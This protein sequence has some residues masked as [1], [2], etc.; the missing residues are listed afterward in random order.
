MYPTSFNAEEE[1]PRSASSE[2]F[3]LLTATPERQKSIDPL[4]F[5]LLAFAVCALGYLAYVYLDRAT[6]QAAEE[7]KFQALMA[8]AQGGEQGGGARSYADGSIGRLTIEAA[9]VSVLVGP[10][11]D[12]LSLRRGAGHIGGTKWPGQRGN[13]GIAGHRDEAFRGLRKLRVG[14]RIRLE[15]PRGSFSYAV[16]SLRTVS[17][18]RVDVLGDSDYQTVTLVTCYPFDYIGSAPLRFVVRARDRKS[19]V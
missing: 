5:G 2:G 12:D 1:A 19:V 8:S 7:K 18:Q 16:E 4:S 15:T 6:Y 13:V 3:P 17:P 9:D 11:S 14:D 10:A